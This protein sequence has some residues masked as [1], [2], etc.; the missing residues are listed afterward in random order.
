[1]SGA[2]QPYGEHALPEARQHIKYRVMHASFAGQGRFTLEGLSCTARCRGDLQRRCWSSTDVERRGSDSRSAPHVSIVRRRLVSG[3][4]LTPLPALIGAEL[5]PHFALLG[6]ATERSALNA[7][8]FQL[9]VKSPP[10]ARRSLMMAAAPFF[11]VLHGEL[12][13]RQVLRWEALA[14]SSLRIPRHALQ[15]RLHGAPHQGV[16]QWRSEAARCCC[17]A[18]WFALSW[19]ACVLRRR[20]FRGGRSS[21][22][23]VTLRATA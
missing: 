20:A 5:K 23:R 16:T 19:E 3:E 9:L 1:M 21:A 10:G 8:S 7:S 18:S 4:G 13:A 6:A 14:A 17:R 15:R 2:A 22:S 11:A 12:R